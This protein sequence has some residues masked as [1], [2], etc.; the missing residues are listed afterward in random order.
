MEEQNQHNSEEQQNTDKSLPESVL[1]EKENTGQEFPKTFLSEQQKNIN[2]A[3][4]YIVVLL[5]ISYLGIRLVSFLFHTHQ[6]IAIILFIITILCTFIPYFR[7][8][9]K[10]YSEDIIKKLP[11]TAICIIMWLLFVPVSFKLFFNLSDQKHSFV[12]LPFIATFLCI[13]IPA[14][15]KKQPNIILIIIQS[16]YVWLFLTLEFLGRL[17]KGVM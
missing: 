5:S 17:L 11:I 1:L 13:G 9:N 16:V 14:I 8:A 4:F 12:F 2:E 10:P 7:K 15:L 6:K 3:F